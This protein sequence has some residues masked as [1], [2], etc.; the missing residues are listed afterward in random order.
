MEYIP[1]PLFFFFNI[2][3]KD[4]TYLPSTNVY[5]PNIVNVVQQTSRTFSACMT[6]TPTDYQFPI[7][8]FLQSQNAALLFFVS[9][10][11]ATFDTSHK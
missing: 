2:V 9:M 1:H 10:N 7:S 6:E 5:L 11:L 4:I 8:P 3:K